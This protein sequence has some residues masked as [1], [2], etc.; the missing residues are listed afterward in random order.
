MTTCPECDSTESFVL[1]T[2]RRRAGIRRR[3][4]CVNG[5][6]YSTIEQTVEA[7][8]SRP[9]NGHLGGAADE[10][11]SRIQQIGAAP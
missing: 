6:R 10:V 7:I 9:F 5:H 3:R 1:D 2:R 11:G 8:I 4:Q